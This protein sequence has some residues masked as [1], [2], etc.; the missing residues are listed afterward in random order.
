[1][2]SQVP[3][4][5]ARGCLTCKKRRKKCDEMKPFCSRCVT[6]GFLCLGYG[7][8]SKA[9]FSADNFASVEPVESIS[10]P[11]PSP[12]FSNPSSGYTS[13]T[14]LPS[15]P[16]WGSSVE[17]EFEGS[18][19]LQS[20]SEQSPRIPLSIPFDPTTIMD[21]VPL[22]IEQC[23]RMSNRIF[24]PFPVEEGLVWRVNDSEITRWTMFIGAKLSQAL[25]EGGRRENY[26][27]WIDRLHGIILGS[28]ASH[29]LAIRDVRARLSGLREATQ[30]ATPSLNSLHPISSKSLPP[31]HTS[32][33][34]TRPYIYPTH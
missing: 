32:G 3:S 10:G 11:S 2:M 29:E 14:S 7:G 13:E 8:Q 34:P 20:T 23:R 33:H 19:I 6:G 9:I 15:S 5:S 27:G 18:L 21:L 17:G 26:L 16:E 30:P 25:S 22:I 31:F 24:R 12:S 28:P 4:R 1:M